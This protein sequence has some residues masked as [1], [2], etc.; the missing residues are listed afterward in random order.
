MQ[1]GHH[2]LKT[3]TFFRKLLAE[4]GRENKTVLEM[5]D[6]PQT[7][8]VIHLVIELVSLVM[9]PAYAQSGAPS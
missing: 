7:A 8:T 5:S 1:V 9:N 4:R 3:L 6:F 2:R